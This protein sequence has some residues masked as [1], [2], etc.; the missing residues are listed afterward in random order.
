MLKIWLSEYSSLILVV[1]NCL[2]LNSQCKL[3]KLLNNL[4]KY[5]SMSGYASLIK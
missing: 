1:P 3:L 4:N 5:R 2:K